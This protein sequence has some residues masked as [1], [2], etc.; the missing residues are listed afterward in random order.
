MVTGTRTI[1]ELSRKRRHDRGEVFLVFFTLLGI[2]WN[3]VMLGG[4]VFVFSGD[5]YFCF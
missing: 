1:R 4:E 3:P 5:M 2:V